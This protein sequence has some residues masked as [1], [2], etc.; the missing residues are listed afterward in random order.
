[1][2]KIIILA[3]IFMSLYAEQK[4]VLSSPSGKF[5]LGQ[6]SDFR[7]DQ[8]LLNTQTGEI[9]QLVIDRNDSLKLSRVLY[10][11]FKKGT[12]DDAFCVSPVMFR[13]DDNVLKNNK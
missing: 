5:V 6:I 12:Y 2:K 7:K 4:A 3:F 11:C 10:N 1:M 9:W 8:F 13:E